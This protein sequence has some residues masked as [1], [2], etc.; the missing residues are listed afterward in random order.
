M[1]VADYI[2]SKYDIESI[3]RIFISGNGAPWIRSGTEYLP[4]AVYVLD[5]FH[6]NEYIKQAVGA[7]KEQLFTLKMALNTADKKEYIIH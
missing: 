7:N 4:R 3:N 6:Q 2:Y 1:E 5:R